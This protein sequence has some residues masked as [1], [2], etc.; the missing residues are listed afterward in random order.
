MFLFDSL[1]KP[2]LTYGS[3]VWAVSEA[4]TSQVDKIFLKHIKYSLGV[5]STT[6]TIMVLGECGQ[7]PPSISCKISLLSYL[8]RLENLSDDHLAKIMYCELK[9]M[10]NLG[11]NTWITN[12]FK[13]VKLYD[14]DVSLNITDFK[15]LCSA[16]VKEHFVRNWQNE[17]SNI[18]S[19]P[20]LRTYNTFKM[21]FSCEPYLISV[22]DYKY[23]NAITRLRTSSHDL[24]IETGRHQKPKIIVQD[25]LCRICNVVE[26]ECH[27]VTR[28]KLFSFRRNQ[29]Y[30]KIRSIFPGF[31]DMEDNDR[32]IFLMSNKDNAVN[33]WFG[34]YVY[35]SFM[36]RRNFLIN[37]SFC[38]DLKKLHRY[39]SAVL[40]FYDIV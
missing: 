18:V 4:G 14:V 37:F 8:N 19:N 6:S 11:F 29:L 38:N 35:S 30:D 21:S 3:E 26:D 13:I 17:L 5:K 31:Q 36:R 9:N 7:Y 24:A 28:C 34:K 10:H 39:Q 20:I 27:F 40:F 1:I 2:I 23:R 32:F 16:R 25:R 22:K 12:A 15:S 33:T